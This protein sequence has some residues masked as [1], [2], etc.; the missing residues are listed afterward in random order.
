MNT[1]VFGA[2]GAF[3]RTVAMAPAESTGAVAEAGTGT[4]AIGAGAMGW[5]APNGNRWDNKHLKNLRC[6]NEFQPG[7]ERNSWPIERMQ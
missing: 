4:D 5:G 7:T 3:A 1:A 2:G 6:E